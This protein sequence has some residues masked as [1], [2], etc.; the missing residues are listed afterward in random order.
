MLSEQTGDRRLHPSAVVFSAS[1]SLRASALPLVLA[2]VGASRSGR[3][4]LVIAAVV[5]GA[6]LL[7][8]LLQYIS[9]RYRFGA[10]ELVVRKGVVFRSERHIP[11]AR[12]QNLDVTQNVL[13]R[14]L[15]VLEVRVQT[16]RGTEPEAVLSAL[17]RGALDDMRARVFAHRAAEL[18]ADHVAAPADRELLAL[19]M[20]ELVIVGL[21]ELRGIAVIAAGLGVLWEVVIEPALDTA[22]GQP[23]IIRIL[24][25]WFRGD[26]F[27][28][29]RLAVTIS[30]AIVL[31]GGLSIMW[32]IVRLYGF[33]L[34]DHGDDLQAACGLFTRVTRTIPRRRIQTVTLREGLLHRLFGRIA[35]EVATAGGGSGAG[36]GKGESESTPIAPVLRPAALPALL[37]DVAPDLDLGALVWQ[38][39]AA[40]TTR[41]V[42]RRSAICAAV[43]AGL[44]AFVVGVWA[45]AVF[46]GL[47]VLAALHARVYARHARWALDHTVVAFRHGWLWRNTTIARLAKVQ[48]VTLHESPFDR[49]AAMAQLRIDTAGATVAIPYLP[50]ETAL[51][52]HARLTTAAAQTEFRW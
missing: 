29:R 37:V 46:G 52:L 12:I 16:G 47:V 49:R 45:V 18:R 50:R 27:D 38:P 5:L 26:V 35:V 1:S 28:P 11:Y 32:A 51:E 2:A 15:G 48:V 33:R 40:R 4:W 6:T 44:S 14:L 19:S 31:I 9:F 20:R 22:A 10:G 13:H 34:L 17:G 3:S 36:S 8:S 24:I 42:F 41:R 23:H 21:V 25:A 43:L 30:V 7:Y 39:L